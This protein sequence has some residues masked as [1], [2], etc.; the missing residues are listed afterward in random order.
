MARTS[1][2]NFSPIR[3]KQEKLSGGGTSS[4]L[5]SFLEVFDRAAGATKSGGTTRRAAKM[6]CLDMDHPEIEDFINWKMREEKKAHALIRGGFSSDF[7][8]E[9]YHTISGQNSNNSVRVTDD[10]MRAALAGRRNLADGRAHD[11]AGLLDVRREGAVA[12]ARRGGV[13]VRR[14]RR[15]VRHDHQPLAH[16]PEYRG[17]PREQPVL[18]VHVPRR[19]GVQPRVGQPHQA[20]PRGDGRDAD[21]RH[22][23]LPPRV[24]H[25]PPGAG[26]PRRSLELPD[27]ADREEQPRLPPARPRLREPRQPAH[28]ARR[29]LRQRPRARGRGQ[30]DRHHVRPCIQDE[31]RRRSD[32]GPVRGLREEP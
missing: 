21:V 27:G 25:V 9:A 12:S 13:G 17:H 31:R 29:P 8:G 14:P 16:V 23:R 22:R 11:G 20:S 10:F 15:A 30:P 32:E 4:G 7:N 24:P 18:R 3:A 5:M 19:L 1:R 2:S 28:A 6:V 26:D